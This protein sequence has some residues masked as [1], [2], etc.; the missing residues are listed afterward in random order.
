M[1][2]AL[3]SLSP[4]GTVLLGEEFLKGAAGRTEP[5]SC[6]SADDRANN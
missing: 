6:L 1:K 2:E 5:K 4:T 3:I